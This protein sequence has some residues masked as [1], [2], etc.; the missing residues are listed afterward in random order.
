MLALL[1]E[2]MVK[3]P[4]VWAWGDDHKPLIVRIPAWLSL[5]NLTR[6]SINEFVGP[7]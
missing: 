2:F 3:Y 7:D 4:S 1:K 5:A 6:I